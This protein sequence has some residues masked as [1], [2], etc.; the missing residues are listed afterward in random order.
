[1]SR[2]EFLKQLPKLVENYKPAS[3]VLRQISELSLLMIVGPSGVGKTSII[4]RLGL[5][6]V[7]SDTTRSARSDEQEGVDYY[8]REDYDKIVDEIKNGRFVQV[9]VDSGGDLKA[10][11]E[12]VYPE[13]G[14][15]VMA[16]VAGAIPIYRQLGFK[17]TLGAFITPPSY[18]EWMA[19]LNSHK[20]T[21]DQQMHRL[22]EAAHS[23]EF[24]L[25]D[26]QMHFILNDELE[27]A[28]AQ[29]ELLI[30]GQINAEREA[31]AC[32]IAKDLLQNVSFNKDLA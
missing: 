28:V 18:D 19:R 11:R 8:F 6:Y 10:T 15:A 16:V 5:K 12:D 7:V 27:K 29:T 9:A 26:P 24:S 22:S 30:K 32:K 2:E 4:N 13:S 20:L 1:M 31:K 21:P 3:D 23:L 14:M 25:S 17:K